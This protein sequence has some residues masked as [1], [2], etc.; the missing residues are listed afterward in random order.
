MEAARGGNGGGLDMIE[1]SHESYGEGLS[2]CSMV[3]QLLS[4]TSVEL[5]W[6]GE[7]HVRATGYPPIIFIDC[8]AR[9]HRSIVPLY[10]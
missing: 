9:S 5:K 1:E 4:T 10:R 6:V 2:R 3:E 7:M 8:I